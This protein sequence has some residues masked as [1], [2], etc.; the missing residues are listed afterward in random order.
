MAL[1]C[2][3]ASCPPRCPCPCWVQRLAPECGHLIREDLQRCRQDGF[4]Q[5]QRSS[6]AEPGFRAA[7]L[8]PTASASFPLKTWPKAVDMGTQGWRLTS[9][10]ISGMGDC[11]PGMEQPQRMGHSSRKSCFMHPTHPAWGGKFTFS[12]SGTGKLVT[13]R[14]PA[15]CYLWVR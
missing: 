12:L 4:L 1:T 10:N 13:Q 6:L 3:V 11:G 14:K 5:L 2:A 7:T 8:Y 9:R 15:I